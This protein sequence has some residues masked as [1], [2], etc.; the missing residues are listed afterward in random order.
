[1][2]SYPHHTTVHS[3]V[4]TRRNSL[5]II[6]RKCEFLWD[7]RVIPGGHAANVHNEFQEYCDEILL[8]TMR[9]VHQDSD[10]Q[11]AASWRATNERDIG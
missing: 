6:S 8:P 1:M 3:G 10:I 7:V 11:T 5:N 2:G 4:V 9:S